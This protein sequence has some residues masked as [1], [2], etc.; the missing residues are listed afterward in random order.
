MRYELM[1]YESGRAVVFDSKTLGTFEV[2]AEN[3]DQARGCVSAWNV[4]DGIRRYREAMA[5][6]G[7]V[8]FKAS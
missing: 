5:E 1:T 8:V 3:E 7:R 4:V 2:R 6:A